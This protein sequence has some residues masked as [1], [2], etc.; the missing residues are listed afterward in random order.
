LIVPLLARSPAAPALFVPPT[1]VNV[2]VGRM[3][4]PS[5]IGCC[6]AL[7]NPHLELP[8]LDLD[9]DKAALEP[10]S[11]ELRGPSSHPLSPSL[12][13]VLSDAVAAVVVLARYRV[14]GERAVG[15]APYVVVF[16]CMTFYAIQRIT[17][18]WAVK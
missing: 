8:V 10:R 17:E 13:A 16:S 2:E 3:L 1:V 7:L 14:R 4:Y 18:S 6:W 15:A 9:L 5:L 12:H 11:A